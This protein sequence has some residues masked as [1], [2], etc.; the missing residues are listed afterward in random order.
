SR[1]ARGRRAGARRGRRR[2]A[3]SQR[4]G[5]ATP[6]PAAPRHGRPRTARDRA[7]AHLALASAA[8]GTLPAASAL[9]A[10][11]TWDTQPFPQGRQPRVIVTM[12]GTRR[13]PGHPG[14]LLE[15]QPAPQSR[16]KY[17][18]LFQ[19]QRLQRPRRRFA[20]EA[21]ALG[22][23]EPVGSNGRPRLV[24]SPPP[25]GPRGAEGPI[26]HHAIEPGNDLGGDYLLG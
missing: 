17:L 1:G 16:D 25:F 26:P 3:P 24:V 10:V 22:R 5:A 21:V 14:D 13:Q 9:R 8:P 15:G 6:A 20:I 23:H 11:R 18:A 7:R 19:R 12:S 2:P 4:R